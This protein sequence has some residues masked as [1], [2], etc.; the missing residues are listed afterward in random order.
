MIPIDLASMPDAKD[1]HNQLGIP[2][3]VNHPIIAHA[4][5]IKIVLPLELNRASRSRFRGER[6]NTPADTVSLILREFS[7]YLER[8]IKDL[9]A[10]PISRVGSH[11]A[12]N[13]LSRFS[14][15]GVK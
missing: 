13:R 5:A 6:S 14:S 12:G 1:E 7:K 10:I 11:A 9:D 8:R 15:T 3:C 2:D 4:D